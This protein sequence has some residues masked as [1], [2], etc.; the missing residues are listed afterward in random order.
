MGR[1]RK[2]SAILELT[3]SFR[4]H[5]DRR[6]AREN[7]PQP[8]PDVGAPPTCLNEAQRARWMELVNDAAPGVL[9][10]A[11]RAILET[12]ARLRQK[13]RDG[14]IKAAEV[15]ILVSCYG[16]L[17]FSPADRSKVT[18]PKPRGNRVNAFSE[19]G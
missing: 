9:T 10:R 5:P 13:E 19:L 4:K 16:R 1:P 6:R 8:E 11:D 2:P 17:G 18:V 14:V 7:E 15:G 3:G 12:M